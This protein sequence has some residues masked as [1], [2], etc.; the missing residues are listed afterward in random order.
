VT[1]AA[2]ELKAINPTDFAS[3]DRILGLAETHSHVTRAEAGQLAQDEAAIDQAINTAGLDATTTST[4]LNQTR[5]VIDHAF[6]DTTT[7]AKGW[8][9]DQQTL[10]QDL[11]GVPG[12]IP[13]ISRTIAQMKVVARA[14]TPTGAMPGI[15]SDGAHV[16][17]V[18]LPASL[19]PRVL[20]QVLPMAWHGLEKAVEA[21]PSAD[22]H[23]LEV[24]YDGQVNNFIKG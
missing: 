11:A 12:V 9:G 19:A 10:Q 24:Y 18:I 6:L 4:D 8:A 3:F 17:N 15:I 5:D 23:P 14:A 16:R 20:E 22:Q 13:L 1:S 21:S 2:T 7:D